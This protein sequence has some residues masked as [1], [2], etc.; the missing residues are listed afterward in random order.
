MGRVLPDLDD[1]W[2]DLDGSESGFIE[3]VEPAPASAFEADVEAV[4]GCLV[5]V[6]VVVSCGRR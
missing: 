3:V 6:H 4:F 5:A 2:S 1:D